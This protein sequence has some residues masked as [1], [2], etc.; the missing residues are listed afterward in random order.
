[1][2]EHR[3]VIIVLFQTLRLVYGLISLSFTEAVSLVLAQ[4]YISVILVSALAF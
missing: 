1:M 2:K 3:N 4:L